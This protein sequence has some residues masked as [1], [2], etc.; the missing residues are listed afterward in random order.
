MLYSCTHMA[1]VGFKGLMVI[2]GG[3]N[4]LIDYAL[5]SY[6]MQKSEMVG[7]LCCPPWGPHYVLHPVRLS[8]DPLLPM[9][10]K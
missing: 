1:T 8:V 9:F 7:L 4:E 3:E 10:L 5:M 6:S 2:S